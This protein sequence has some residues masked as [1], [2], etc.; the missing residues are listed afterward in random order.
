MLRPRLGSKTYVPRISLTTHLVAKRNL[1]N[2]FFNV[3]GAPSQFR[4][5]IFHAGSVK[6][7]LTLP[8]IPRYTCMALSTFTLHFHSLYHLFSRLLPPF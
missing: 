3:V 6:C 2:A 5:V 4:F 8:C 7:N 1:L